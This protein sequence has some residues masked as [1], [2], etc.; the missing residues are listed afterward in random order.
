M[1]TGA[2]ALERGLV[3]A[4][5]GVNRAVAIARKLADIPEDERVSVLELG[6][7]ETSPLALLGLGASVQGLA[8]TLLGGA[9]LPLGLAGLLPLLSEI[10][11]A[12]QPSFVMM[13]VDVN[14]LG[15]SAGNSMWMAENRPGSIA[16][17][18]GAQQGI[19]SR[20]WEAL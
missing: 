1:W 6:R 7:K 11:Q 8:S 19:F 2:A 16:F 20:L 14:S 5:G 13:E 9:L 3:D 15:S 10:Q 18:E 17:D 12:G 4:L